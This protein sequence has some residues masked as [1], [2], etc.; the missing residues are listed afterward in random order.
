MGRGKKLAE[1]L[2]PAF[3]ARNAVNPGI[4]DRVAQNLDALEVLDP[5]LAARV[6]AQEPAAITEAY[7]AI[8][9]YARPFESRRGLRQLR[10]ASPALADDLATADHPQVIRAAEALAR[11][12]AFIPPDSL[13]ISEGARMSKAKK[14]ASVMGD[15]AR[16]ADNAPDIRRLI[17][18]LVG[19][20]D[21]DFTNPEVMRLLPANLQRGVL[22]NDPQAIA[23]A[24]QK[25][26][27]Q[28]SARLPTATPME[29]GALIP[30]GGRGVPVGG[31]TGSG[32]LMPE[33]RALSTEVTPQPRLPGPPQRALPA[34]P[35][36]A[37]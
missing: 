31:P 32:V 20:D 16:G 33:S 29:G 17:G 14:A 9:Q 35:E 21:V 37:N 26:L 6:R 25:V 12:E 10:E 8:H 24:T 19:A 13:T 7:E 36:P 3:L 30:Q 28:N 23:F 22:A 34:P 27:S 11:Q 2:E 5:A 15:V 4:L 18:E 1:L